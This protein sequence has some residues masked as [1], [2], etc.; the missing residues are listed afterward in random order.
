MGGINQHWY[1]E[2]WNLGENKMSLLSANILLCK[3]D[4]IV[5]WNLFPPKFMYWSPNP[6]YD[7]IQR[8]GFKE[9]IIE[10]MRTDVLRDSRTGVLETPGVHVHRGEATWEQR[11]WSS[12]CPIE[13]PQEK[14][15]LSTPWCWTYSLQRYKKLNFC[16]SL[17]LKSVFFC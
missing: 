15:N 9:V 10:V 5:D 7:Y 16:L 3:R 6:P 8:K 14:P 12:V 17:G 13:Q 4:T 2:A 11:R 1:F